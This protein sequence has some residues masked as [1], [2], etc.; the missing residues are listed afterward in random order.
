LKDIDTVMTPES[1]DQ[2]PN[3]AWIKALEITILVASS[4]I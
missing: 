2:T 3:A 4:R 1:G